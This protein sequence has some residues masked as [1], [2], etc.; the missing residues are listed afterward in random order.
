MFQKQVIGSGAPGIPAFIFF[1]TDQV[2]YVFNC[3]EG[4]QR[5]CHEH[6][7]KLSKIDHIFL[8][9]LSWKNVGGLPGL[10]LTAQDSG[11]TDLRIHSPEGIE[12]LVDTVQSFI[13]LPRLKITY[14]STSESESFKDHMMTVMYVPLTRSTEKNVMDENEYDTNENGKRASNSVEN[15]EKRIKVTS[16]IVC[17]I[18][19]IHP[20]HGKLLIDKCLQLGIENGP[21]RNLLKSG[22]NVTKEDG[23][24]IYS[25][26]VSTPAGP[27][28]TF[29]GISKNV[30]F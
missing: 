11:I 2:N 23:S 25:K 14:P 28:L 6:H 13:N 26:D 21:I 20:K 9:N 3:G 22:K 12:S 30:Y 27:K 5:L 29:M 8:T 19:E 7:C 4:T 18:C 16:K 17:Y 24:V 1:T 15:R 10:L